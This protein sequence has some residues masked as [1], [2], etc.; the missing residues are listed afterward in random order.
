MITRIVLYTCIIYFY[1]PHISYMLYVC[2]YKRIILY[3]RIV[4]LDIAEDTCQKMSCLGHI[5]ETLA[6]TT[7]HQPDMF[8]RKWV[9]SWPIRPSVAYFRFRIFP[10][11]REITPPIKAPI[12]F[13]LKCVRLSLAFVPISFSRIAFDEIAQLF[14][15]FWPLNS[16][17]GRS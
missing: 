11:S 4:K 2:V 12:A 7:R 5:L 10:M 3:I 17:V 14:T 1:G 15:L 8:D 6:S 16:H 9:G 13:P